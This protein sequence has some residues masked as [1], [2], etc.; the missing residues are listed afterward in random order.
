[1]Y[2]EQKHNKE[3]NIQKENDKDAIID[4]DK[5]NNNL[6]KHK[7]THSMFYQKA[8]D[9]TTKLVANLQK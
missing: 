2:T 6:L 9:Y 5:E 4:C 7:R 1:L 3:R 8:Q